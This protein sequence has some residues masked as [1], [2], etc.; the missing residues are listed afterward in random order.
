[1]RNKAHV[2]LTATVV[3]AVGWSVQGWAGRVGDAVRP[4]DRSASDALGEGACTE[5]A[6]RGETS[7][8]I[9]DWSDTDRADLEVAM[10]SGAAVV[11]YSCAG[12]EVLSNCRVD[13]GYSY[14]GL[15]PKTQ[16]VEM[17]DTASMRA[18]FGG[19]PTL[20]AKMSAELQQGSSLNL[21]YMMVGMQA[22][23]VNAVPTSGLEGT[24]AGATHIVNRAYIGAFV[25]DTA[26]AGSARAAV[27]VLGV[28]GASGGVSSNSASRV[29]DGNVSACASA[30]ANARNPPGG[31]AAMLRVNLVPIGGKTG[32]GAGAADARGCPDGFVYADDRC[33]RP[34]EVSNYLCD[35]D[36]PIE[37]KEQCQAGSEAS[38]GRYAGYLLRT[39][40]DPDTLIASK[41]SEIK[42]DLRNLVEKMNAACAAGEANACTI[43]GLAVPVANDRIYAEGY[44]TAD[45]LEYM[46]KGCQGGESYGCVSVIDAYGLGLYD[47]EGD[48]NDELDI[49]HLFR[50][51]AD[52]E[53]MDRIAGRA[54]RQGA[55]KSCV[56]LADQFVYQDIVIKHFSTNERALKASRYLEHACHGGVTATCLLAGATQLDQARCQQIVDFITRK[57]SD[58]YDINESFKDNDRL[59]KLTAKIDDPQR[60]LSLIDE[61]CE[62]G[63]AL[64][65]KQR[66]KLARSIR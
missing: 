24:C 29:A 15:S 64:A 38:C 36:E 60:G 50:V 41:A 45:Y 31:C 33:A 2:L 59:C 22:S 48:P 53:R 23:A 35:K 20:P 55:A 25:M 13:G 17:N 63:D 14:V 21:A 47:S 5:S 11:R 37:C 28:G 12:I 58:G 6:L 16:I 32:Y 19:L 18:N 34:N 10:R 66:D 44:E 56:T 39:Y 49:D 1:M 8:F 42:A 3:M 4:D 54:C 9:A 46:E 7:P 40:V 30:N 61:A 43:S 57:T 65:C 26:A 62:R 51:D 27:K 52:P